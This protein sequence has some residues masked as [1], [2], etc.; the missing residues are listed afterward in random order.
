[1]SVA[2]SSATTQ[3]PS[4][5]TDESVTA[6]VELEYTTE[7]EALAG[8]QLG[9][10]MYNEFKFEAAL[11]PQVAVLKFF[12][13]KHGQSSK[14]CGVY[15]LDY[16]LSLLSVIQGVTS[17]EDAALRSIDEEDAETCFVNLDMARVC[18]EKAEGDDETDVAVQR[19]LADVHDA[20]AQFALEQDNSQAALVEFEH[21]IHVLMNLP[22]NASDE[23]KTINQITSIMFNSA[24]CFIQEADFPGATKKLQDLLEFSESSNK[25]FPDVVPKDLLE[26]VRECLDECKDNCDN[27]T[28]EATRDAIKELYPGEDQEVPSPAEVLEAPSA[29]PKNPYLSAIPDGGLGLMCSNSMGQG[30]NSLLLTPVPYNG[31]GSNSTSRS[32]FPTQG[33]GERSRSFSASNGPVNIAVVRKKAKKT[34]ATET[35]DAGEPIEKK[36][37]VEA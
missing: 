1:M 34:P 37:R 6:D 24:R 2:S 5:T 12:T 8:R 28:F 9:L 25:K 30:G 13:K 14:H 19:Q 7:E 23:P 35:A 29:Q 36:T 15:Y 4:S 16:G 33:Y 3:N 31:E 27:K 32:M 17:A 20:L 11:A 22:N 21:S 18:F 26:E 10:R